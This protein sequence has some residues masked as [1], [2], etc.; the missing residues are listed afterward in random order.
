MVYSYCHSLSLVILTALFPRES[1]S[2]FRTKVLKPTPAWCSPPAVFCVKTRQLHVRHSVSLYPL[3]TQHLPPM[4]LQA[5]WHTMVFPDLPFAC[6]PNSPSPL[7]SLRHFLVVILWPRA[8]C[9]LQGWTALTEGK[10]W[11]L[12]NWRTLWEEFLPSTSPISNQCASTAS[13]R[14]V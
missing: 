14:K 10:A 12:M 7:P 9:T 8:P 2:Q 13:G 4:L 1:L 11:W 3:L 5:L 6:K